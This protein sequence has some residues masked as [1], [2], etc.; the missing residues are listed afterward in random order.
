M[1]RH[2]GRRLLLSR[3]TQGI[4]SSGQIRFKATAPPRPP[5]ADLQSIPQAIRELL[6]EPRKRDP[7]APTKKRRGPFVLYRAEY[8]LTLLRR[9]S[10]N[11]AAVSPLF[12]WIEV[13][14]Y[15]DPKPLLEKKRKRMLRER[16]GRLQ[17][18]SRVK[19]QFTDRGSVMAYVRVLLDTMLPDEY[20]RNTRS[21]EIYALLEEDMPNDLF[22]WLGEVCPLI[23]EL[24]L[25][26]EGEDVEV[27]AA[28]R[29][30]DTAD[31]MLRRCYL[32]VHDRLP[33][34]PAPFYESAQPT[35]ASS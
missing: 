33:P 34:L 25:Q 13:E 27:K 26:S 22:L 30:Q 9:M 15:F 5:R 16:L 32:A 20:L 1:Y 21:A 24:S 8:A 7:N 29:I 31:D 11:P 17:E 35:S 3:N 12:I 19:P 10:L 18:Q 23:Y 28:E 2:C 14:K 4:L 6:P